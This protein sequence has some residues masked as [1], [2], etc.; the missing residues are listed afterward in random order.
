MTLLALIALVAVA[1]LLGG[2]VFFAALVAPLVFRVL[3]VEQGGQ[4][5]RA[6]FPRYYVFVLG[7][8]AA[9]AVALFPLSK[10]DAGIMAATAGL[11]WWLRQSLMPRINALSDR[12]KAGDTAAQPEFDR[13]HRLSV[14]A[15]L[16]QMVAAAVVLA[17]FVT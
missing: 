9:A 14:I 15:N 2:M 3:P 4:F 5:V 16:L 13:A 8:A 6:L 10:P 1:L 7:T 17:G 11:A 12:A